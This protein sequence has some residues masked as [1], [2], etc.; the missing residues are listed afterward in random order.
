M[1]SAKDYKLIFCKKNLKIFVIM[2]SKNSNILEKGIYKV[3]FY[4]KKLYTL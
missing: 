1:S 2:L 4:S 3:E